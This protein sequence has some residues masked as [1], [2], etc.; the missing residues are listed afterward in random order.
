MA[1]PTET[2]TTRALRILADPSASRWLKQALGVCL[3]RDAVDAANDAE[4][5]FGV[6]SQRADECCARPSLTDAQAIAGCIEHLNR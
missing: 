5:L 4:L 2:S 1:T 3:S 6:L